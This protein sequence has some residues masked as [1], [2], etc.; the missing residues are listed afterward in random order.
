MKK[1]TN[2]YYCIYRYVKFIFIII[3]SLSTY[4]EW[5]LEQQCG[6][7]KYIPWRQS[8]MIL[9]IKSRFSQTSSAGG[10]VAAVFK[11]TVQ[12]Q[13]SSPQCSK[14]TVLKRNKDLGNFL[15]SVGSEPT[16][17]QIWPKTLK[18]YFDALYIHSLILHYLFFWSTVQQQQL[19]H[20]QNSID[21]C[22]KRV[23]IRFNGPDHLFVFS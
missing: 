14:K 12:Q 6:V 8:A 23:F 16:D 20:S 9:P 22:F 13:H 11:A 21:S 4:F 7:S 19:L 17:L 2:Q 3:N 18:Y 1:E 10:G 5:N 15:E